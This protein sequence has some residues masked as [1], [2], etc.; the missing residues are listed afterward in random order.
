MTNSG[1]SING[2]LLPAG[3][4]KRSDR[5]MEKTET[6]QSYFRHLKK[7]LIQLTETEKRKK[8]VRG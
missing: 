7:N 6:R 5:Q 4:K 3:S 1:I 2:I 8:N